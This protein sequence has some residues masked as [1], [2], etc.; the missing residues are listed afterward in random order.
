M[1]TYLYFTF[2]FF[3]LL[4]ESAF[5]S[6]FNKIKVRAREHY[7]FNSFKIDNQSL[8]YSGFSN[9]INI[10]HEVPF[11]YSI[12]LAISPIIGKSKIN[13]SDKSALLGDKIQILNLGIEYKQFFNLL[14]SNQIFFRTGAS[15][16]KIE[17]YGT[18]SD[19]TGVSTYLG[20]GYEFKYK[21]MGIAPEMAMRF[22]IL[23][24][25]NTMRSITPSIGFHFYNL[26]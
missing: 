16:L 6:F 1:K 9:T 2:L 8:D 11:K 4:S 13:D 26:L 15:W 21:N 23:E 25:G 3:I 22:G 12:G 5:G 14:N 19:L 24:K 17:S 20:L 18:Y 7:E 10:W